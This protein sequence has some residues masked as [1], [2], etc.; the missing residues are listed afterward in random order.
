MSTTTTPTLD[1]PGASVVYDVRGPLPAPAGT[2]PLLCIAQPMTAAGFAT[3]ASYLPDR[4]V[5]T[6]DPRGLGRSTRTDGRSDN[7]PQ[8]QAEDLHR[9]LGELG[10]VDLL[11]S[12]GGAVTGL[13]LVSRHPDDVRTYVAHEPPLLAVLPDADQAFAAERA[14]QDAYQQRGWGAGMAAFIALTSWP[15]ELTEAF[16]RQL[17]DPAAFGMPAQDD[18]S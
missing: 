3:L 16:G 13:E 10:P 17:P 9:L 7:T 6:Y 11:G 8:Q 2:L 18:G 4:T 1:V 12:S 15:G 14:V 5:V